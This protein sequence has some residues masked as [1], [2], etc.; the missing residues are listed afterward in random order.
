MKIPYQ[1]TRS[2]FEEY[3]RAA[4]RRLNS[5][6]GAA[7]AA[8][9][10]NMVIYIPLGVAAMGFYHFLSSHSGR[11]VVPVQIA[12][13][14]LL[15]FFVLAFLG[16]WAQRRRHF[17]SG[18]LDGGWFLA[19][20]TLT[21]SAQGIETRCE[22]H[23]FEIAWPGILAIEQTENLILLFVDGMG[24]VVVP[25]R[26]FGSEDEWDGFVREIESQIAGTTGAAPAH[27]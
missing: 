27:K 21:L 20:S 1:L 16:R 8:F 19:P 9:G 7:Y 5:S 11:D 12:A 18:V 14:A 26:A 25:K 17:I 13:G 23:R 15:L 6:S 22:H 10:W 4:W 2:D 3:S 24:A